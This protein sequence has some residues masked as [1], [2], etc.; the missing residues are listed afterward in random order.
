VRDEYGVWNTILKANPD[1]TSKIQHGMKYKIKVE[2]PDGTK[3]S[4]FL[5]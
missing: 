5:T 4:L 2:Y 3:V 1:G